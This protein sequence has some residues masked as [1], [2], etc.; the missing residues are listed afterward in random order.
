RA[1]ALPIAVDIKTLKRIMHVSAG[2]C[3]TA[4]LARRVGL[5]PIAHHRVEDRDRLFLIGHAVGDVRLLPC[6]ERGHILRFVGDEVQMADNPNR[7]VSARSH[8]YET[9]GGEQDNPGK[10]GDSIHRIAP[11]E[12]GTLETNE[13]FEPV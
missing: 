1:A 8:A 10:P 9:N 12:S 5:M 4:K 3:R 7:F 13:L 11:E 2:F 6:F